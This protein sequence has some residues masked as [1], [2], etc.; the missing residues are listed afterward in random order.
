LRIITASITLVFVP[1]QKAP[2]TSPEVPEVQGCTAIF[3]SRALASFIKLVSA[4]WRVEFESILIKQII[5]A[6]PGKSLQAWELL[7]LDFNKSRLKHYL[8]I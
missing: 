1:F 7:S 3:C 5:D 8:L 6:S 4:S 2:L